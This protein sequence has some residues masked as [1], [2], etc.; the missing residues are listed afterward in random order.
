MPQKSAELSFTLHL[1]APSNP[2]V[3]VK[4]SVKLPSTYP[5]TV[6]IL[7]LSG[8]D[9]LRPKTRDEV[10]SFVTTQPK[11]LL[12]SEM[13]FELGSTI[14]DMMEDDALARAEAAENAM[15][16][17]EEERMVREAAANQVAKEQQ[18]Q[19][20]RKMEADA[21][22]E[23]RVLGQLV[24]EEVKRRQEMIRLARRKSSAQGNE[25]AAEK[26]TNLSDIVA[27]DQP[28][29]FKD[30]ESRLASFRAVYGKTLI[31]KS[32]F[33]EVSIV[34]PIV[35]GDGINAP[36]LV[37]KEIILEQG[38]MN[39]GRFRDRLR[40]SE[41]RLEALKNLRHPNIV[42]FVSFKIYRGLD[43]E[44]SGPWN[45]AILL[46]FAN[47]G[48][49]FEFLDI[50]ES[51]GVANVRSWMIQLL[52]ALNYYHRHG[53]VHENIH[54]GNVM[55]FRPKSSSTIV[56][57]SDGFHRTLPCPPRDAKFTTSTS[58]SWHAPELARDSTK[59]TVKT[60]VWDLGIVFLQ[61]AFGKDVLRRYASPNALIG[62][63]ELS[64]SL[65]IILRQL[66]RVD[67]K[68][69][70]SAFDL[71][72][73]E[74]LRDDAPFL[75]S[76]SISNSVM[77]ARPSRVRHDSANVFNSLSRYANDFVEAGRLG[78][79]G[80]GEVVKARNKLDGRFYAIKKIP[81]LSTSTDTLQEIM[82]LSQLN[83]PYVVRYFTAWL[84][85]DYSR[86]QDGSSE[87]VTSTEEVSTA[88]AKDNIE[89]GFSTGGLDFI[90]SSGY[91][92]IQFGY[93]SEDDDEAVG[94]EDE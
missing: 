89:F 16:S 77:S 57:L 75:V 13:I 84:E 34:K 25:K 22:E 5:K 72:P 85:Q 15:P 30:D 76:S 24:E 53:I 66:F 19:M 86:L 74:F 80:F 28:I 87:A 40:S 47:K 26:D 17:L 48:S 58:P 18:E 94:S 50:A 92:K 71:L 91:P 67:P 93:D 45:V 65:E 59:R 61:M 4:L 12:G 49:L 56:K 38:K 35:S 1:K 29:A 33:S 7:S 78:K 52:E 42:D 21:A 2:A 79:G 70:P 63:R 73:S 69:R 14:Q 41:E 64:D 27:F 83:H 51:V 36:L 62:A 23:E 60:D 32:S 68:K 81:Q 46:E 20:L 82:L 31:S 39:D 54:C 44:V 8:L 90:S 6:P 43:D 3:S 37:L 88:S 10:R 55:L 9:G 11:S